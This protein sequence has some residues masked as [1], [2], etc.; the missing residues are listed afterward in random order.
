MKCLRRKY[1]ACVK[2][3]KKMQQDKTKNDGEIKF[4]K[5]SGQRMCSEI[6]VKNF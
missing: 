1:I 5:N 4:K 3:R 6:S 2:I